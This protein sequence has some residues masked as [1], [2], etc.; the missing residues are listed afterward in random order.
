MLSWLGPILFFVFMIGQ[1]AAF[2]AY[3]Y[4]SGRNS[5]RPALASRAE[6]LDVE[7]WLDG[8]RSGI[9]GSLRPPP[10]GDCV[11]D[12]PILHGSSTLSELDDMLTHITKQVVLPALPDYGYV[13]NNAPLPSVTDVF[14][15]TQRW[16]DQPV[17][18]PWRVEVKN[19]KSF[20]PEHG[21]GAVVSITNDN[22]TV[23]IARVGI[24]RTKT[25]NPKRTFK[26]QMNITLSNA[27]ATADIYNEHGVGPS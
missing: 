4:R 13:K 11:A 27:Q 12:R 17:F 6:M 25:L 5:K 23:R 14:A 16:L 19:D 9:G 2:Y 21:P 7:R 20:G 26:E 15:K 18:A 8:D 3:G 10:P 22:D 1:G 24:D